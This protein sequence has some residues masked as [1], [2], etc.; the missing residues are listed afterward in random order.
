MKIGSTTQTDDTKEI[1]ANVLK[2]QSFEDEDA[3]ALLIHEQVMEQYAETFE[4][5][6]Q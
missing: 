4:K 3:N 5:L 2:Q 1:P 6:A